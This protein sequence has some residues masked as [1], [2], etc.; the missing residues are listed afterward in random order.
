MDPEAI[1]AQVQ[2]SAR[3]GYRL[4]QQGQWDAARA[5]FQRALDRL[6]SLIDGLGRSAPR[7]LYQIAAS[8]LNNLGSVC[9][10]QGDMAQALAY[11]REAVRIVLQIAPRSP[12]AVIFLDNLGS[13]YQQQGDLVQALAFYRQAL[14]TDQVIAPPSSQTAK[15]LNNIGSVYQEQGDPAQARVYAREALRIVEQIAPRSPE[16]VTYHANLGIVLQAQGELAEA[17]KQ[18]QQAL[19]IDQEIAPPSPQTAKCL[20][21]I[22]AVYQEQGDLAQQQ[23]DLA[24]A[25]T[26]Y[27]Q[28]LEIMAQIAPRSRAMANCLSKTGAA[29]QEQG[30]LEQ[31]LVCH[32]Q[33]LEIDRE[34]APHSME[35][36]R[37]L[38]NIGAVLQQQGDL[39]QALEHLQEALHIERQ[40]A[41]RS[42]ET[43]ACLGNIGLVYRLQGDLEAAL[44]YFQEALG[45]DRQIDPRSTGTA[46]DLNNIGLVYR[47]RGDLAQALQQYRQALALAQ[48]IAPRSPQTASSLNNVGFVY[49]ELGELAPARQHFEQALAIMQP[50]APHSPQAAIYLNNLGLVHRRQGDLAR[51]RARFQ[52]ALEIVHAIAPR[53]HEAAS[54][55]NNLGFVYQEQGDRDAALSHHLRAVQVIEALRTRA[56][57]ERAREGLFAQHQGTYHALIACLFARDHPGDHADAFHYAER[58]RARTLID[59]LSESKIEVR[60]DTPEQQALLDEERALQSRLA[61]VVNRLTIVRADR[62][63]GAGLLDRLQAEERQMAERLDSLRAR[64]RAALPQYAQIQYPDPL[65]LEQVQQQLLDPGTLLLEYHTSGDELFVWAV[66]QN[67]FRMQPLPGSA[68]ELEALLVQALQRYR[69]DHPPT[70]T[71]GPGAPSPPHTPAEETERTAQVRLGERLLDVV[72][73][74]LWQ[75]VTRVLIVPDGPLHYLPFELLPFRGRLLADRCPLT[76]APSATVLDNLRQ[77]WDR[78]PAPPHGEAYRLEF[79]GFGDPAFPDDPDEPGDS[80]TDGS[81]PPGARGF[82]FAPLPGTREEVRTVQDLFEGR[83]KAFLDVEATEH[84]VRALAED[85]RYVHFATHGWF[86]E[87]RPLYSGIAL[88]PPQ[89][90]EPPDGDHLLQVY[91]MFSLR[92]RAELVVCSACETGLGKL[93]AGEGLVG[94]SRALFYAGAKCLLV[95]LWKVDDE[96]TKDFMVCFYRALREG[97]STLDALGVA[98]RTLRDDIWDDPYFWAAFIPIGLPE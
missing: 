42:K 31:A 94:M 18:Y 14:E 5:T 76:Y 8:L 49:Q 92:L 30:D 19:E 93:Q 27:Q 84:N 98:R 17:L 45:I 66:R 20:G 26:C 78:R 73:E 23:G 41:P 52:E 51:A 61:A 91:E 37:D 60:A 13:I 38:N 46:R 83:G 36:A 40:I 97:K 63:A 9:R 28:A 89:P 65:T 11:A 6:S 22:G 1:R 33:A 34:N 75:G 55:L 47:Q 64:I 24:Q 53:S 32:R 88:A 4:F 85:C 87:E 71:V 57:G 50:I 39:A 54:C 25:L 68:A 86:H 35:T 90:G 58:S 82:R 3:D 59:L 29:Y 16:A 48:E 43:A 21:H 56:G 62:R 15:E 95:S 7:D 79:L 70:G 10:R 81:P 96:A 67:G 72:P 12:E 44:E 77:L 69:Q 2:Q 74:A 80:A